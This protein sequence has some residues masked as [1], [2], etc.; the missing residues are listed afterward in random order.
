MPLAFL[1]DP[2]KLR[3]DDQRHFADFIE[4]HGPTAGLFEKAAP[5]L[6]GTGKCAFFM[7][8]K[9]TLHQV[10][11]DTRTVYRHERFVSS[12]AKGVDHP[13]DKFFSGSV[14]PEDQNIYRRFTDNANQVEDV[15]HGLTL[16]YDLGAMDGRLLKTFDLFTEARGNGQDFLIKHHRLNRD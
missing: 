11:R 10:L 7:P 12:I 1:D 6:F 16:C 3:L 4:K 9:L 15:D 5:G 13:G 14:L 8:E 2:Q